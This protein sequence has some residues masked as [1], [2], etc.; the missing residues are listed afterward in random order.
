MSIP[1]VPFRI[2]CFVCLN[3]AISVHLSTERMSHSFFELLRVTDQF[4][5]N[6][7]GPELEAYKLMLK[8]ILS[9]PRINPDEKKLCR[10]YCNEH[11][12]DKAQHNNSTLDLSLTRKLICVLTLTSFATIWLESGRVG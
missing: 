9:K 11:S 5:Q 8:T 1:L 4:L 6:D 7:A 10:T 3:A 12:I 2:L